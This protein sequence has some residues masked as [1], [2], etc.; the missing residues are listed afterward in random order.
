LLLSTG[1]NTYPY[2]AAVAISGLPSGVSFTLDR[3]SVFVG[4]NVVATFA[5]QAAVPAGA[6]AVTITATGQAGVGTSSRSQ[7]LQLE[8]L[9]AG[10]TTVTGRV[11]HADDA[12]P[13]VGARIRLAGV[14]AFT[15][16]TG[17]YRFVSPPVL[18]DQVLL[19]D[20]NTANTPTE[21]FP[22]GI[23]MPVMIVGGQD[24]KVLT[25]Y[26]QK[27]DPTKFT[28]VVPGAAATVTNPDIPNFSLNI[29]QGATLIGWDGQ[30]ITKINVRQV[31][32]RS[33]A[34]QANP[35]RDQ[36]P[37]RLSLL[38]LPRRRS[39]PDAADPGDDGER[40]RRVAW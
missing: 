3:P 14:Q 33:P 31:P 17:T 40:R 12:S 24:N 7:I 13:F 11:L 22:S 25:S 28:N 6:Y 5:A 19:V 29:P 30:P 1:L 36:H 34:D 8:V 35:G 26:I 27:V 21:E 16:A 32:N 20:G 18:G 2:A 4:G 23:A 9:A 10:S 37:Q 39:E 38:L 15:D